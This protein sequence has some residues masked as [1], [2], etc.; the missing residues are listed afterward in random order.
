MATSDGKEKV[1]AGSYPGYAMPSTFPVTVPT[2]SASAPPGGWG[3]NT[4]LLPHPAPFQG[5]RLSSMTKT[6][7]RGK[8]NRINPQHLGTCIG[9][10]AEQTTLKHLDRRNP[11]GGMGS[12]RQLATETNQQNDKPS[13]RKQFLA[14]EHHRA[15]G[16]APQRKARDCQPCLE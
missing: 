11:T 14:G 5:P 9:G 10:E 16:K 6:K 12:H 7:P 2:D 3:R 8:G 1:Q 4:A 13:I 15:V